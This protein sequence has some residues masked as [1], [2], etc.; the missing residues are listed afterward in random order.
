MKPGDRPPDPRCALGRVVES[1]HDVQAIKS[2]LFHR[3]R[4]LWVELDDPALT[5]DLRNS[6]IWLGQQL[7]PREGT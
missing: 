1:E 2:D 3:Q 5:P 7:Y 6:A 4:H